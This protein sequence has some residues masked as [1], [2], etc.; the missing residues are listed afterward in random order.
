VARDISHSKRERD[1]LDSA[2]AAI[3]SF[4]AFADRRWQYDYFSK[5]CEPIF[6]YTLQE[7]MADGTI[8]VR[9]VLPEDLERTLE[10]LHQAIFAGR[11]ITLEYRFRHHD[12]RICWL[13]GTYSSR[14]DE[15]ASCW[16]VTG[17]STDISE[18]KATKLALQE[19]ERRY[20]S[21]TAAVPVGI[22]RTDITGNCLYVN[23][24]CCEITGLTPQAAQQDGWREALHPEDRERI[25]AQWRECVQ[26]HLPF[27]AEYRFQRADGAIAW[28]LGQ[29]VAERGIDGE[30]LGY[31]GS[32]TDISD[33]KQ[34][35]ATLRQQYARSQLLAE[36][37]LK[38]R[39]SLQL[40]EILQ[41]SVT[42]VQRM[43]QAD[44]VLIFEIHPDGSGT[45]VQEAVISPWAAILGQDISDPC[46]PRS[47]CDLYRQGRLRAVADIENGGL[48]PCYVK[49]LQQFA[50]KAHLIVPILQRER[51]W[52]LLIAHQCS[53]RRSWLSE[54]TELLQQLANQISI[55][56]AQS[57]LV[58]ALRQSERRF[59]QIAETIDEVFWMTDPGKQG[60]IYVSPAYERIWG[61]SC[62][63]L[64]GSPQQWVEAIHPQDRDR[65]LAL[66]DKQGQGAY[67]E[68]YR[69]IR[70]DGE[71]RWIRDR[72]FPI[73]D[74][75][76]KLYRVTG[77]AQDITER[78][79]AE[80]A[81]RELNQDLEERVRERTAQLELANQELEAFSYSVSHDLKAPL[82]SLN[83][84]S[85]ALLEDYGG[86]L[87]E[88]ARDYLQRIQAA[89][90]RMATLIDALLSLSRVTRSHLQ[91]QS[92]NL[93]QMA[94][95]IRLELQQTYGR[96]EIEWAIAPD[97]IAF[98][99]AR[100]LRIVLENLID[101]ACKFTTQVSRP[102]IELGTCLEAEQQIY[103]VRDNGAGFDMAYADKLFNAFQRLHPQSK[104][105]GTGI[106][107][108]TVQRIIHRHGGRVW[109]ESASDRGATFY[110]SLPCSH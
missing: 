70:P 31:V 37:T 108:V 30:W 65:F 16:I 9:S 76:G 72:A 12:G 17:I 68:E 25:F 78:K 89:S 102:R 80:I 106:G 96:L 82:R 59:R 45:I 85:Q 58:D 13:S 43:L 40:E 26:N 71:I 27:Q 74:Q 24:R 11:A 91:Y 109:A 100:L 4:R 34:A 107:L 104:F 79:Q 92:V 42:E 46:F 50:V 5:G 33:R 77:I 44:R 99:D 51:L 81:L 110:W 90:Q 73:Y 6:G 29:A 35:E 61:Y 19:S 103:F 49:F 18:Y 41:T 23:D 93:S 52:G 20:V 69:I 57:S 60:M 3:V 1:I 56:L 48:Q 7:L 22:F 94:Q 98:G 21:L 8:W 87:D 39:Q 10:R 38:I 28:V 54:E 75:T 83:G 66:W 67:D 64:Y 36:V 62:Q 2:I 86:V 47:H 14:W 95:E 97:M 55:A 53:H 105:P 15:S 88:I 101:N 32:I 63:S 84:F